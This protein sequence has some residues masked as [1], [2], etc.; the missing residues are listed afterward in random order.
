MNQVNQEDFS[1]VKF[2][3]KGFEKLLD[4][5]QDQKSMELEQLY[6]INN[7][8][9]P[10]YSLTYVCLALIILILCVYLYRVYKSKNKPSEEVQRY[11]LK[12]FPNPI[13]KTKDYNITP[14]PKLKNER[15]V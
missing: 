14:A 12:K 2:S 13:P 8:H 15:A 9:I 5:I 11:E 7:T 6:P 10:H 4:S 3:Q 1:Q